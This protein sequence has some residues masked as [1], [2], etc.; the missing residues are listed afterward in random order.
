MKLLATRQNIKLGSREQAGNSV[1]FN[2]MLQAKKPG[3]SLHRCLHYLKN[4]IA[5]HN[6]LQNIV[7]FIKIIRNFIFF[8]NFKIIF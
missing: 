5:A 1:F 2:L 3:E 8:G 7:F 6:I 4:I